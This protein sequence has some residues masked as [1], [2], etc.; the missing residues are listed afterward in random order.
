V[1]HFATQ[2][3]EVEAK[4]ESVLDVLLFC[5]DLFGGLPNKTFEEQTTMLRNLLTEPVAAS[6]GV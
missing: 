4:R 6:R 5:I 1:L 2:A 3:D